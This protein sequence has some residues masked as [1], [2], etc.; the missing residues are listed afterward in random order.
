MSFI[1]RVALVVSLA[2]VV[3]GCT[4][5]PQI[6]L[7]TFAIFSEKRTSGTCETCERHGVRLFPL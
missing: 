7:V 1:G 5:P 3:G 6:S 4:T 2:L